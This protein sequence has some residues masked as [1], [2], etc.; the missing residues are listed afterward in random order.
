MRRRSARPPGSR[1][2]RTTSPCCIGSRGRLAEAL[3]V[4]KRALVVREKTLG[5]DHVDVGQSLDNLAELYR[6]NAATPKP[7]RSTSVPSRSL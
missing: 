1:R 7:S 5:S 4:F 6:G 3:L 2:C